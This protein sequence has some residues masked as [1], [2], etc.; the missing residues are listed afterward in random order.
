MPRKLTIG[1]NWQG[2]LDFKALIDRARLADQAGVHSIWVAEAWGRD[3]FTLLT[4]L[5]EH[6]SKAQLA[7]SIVNPTRAPRPPSR[8]ISGRSTS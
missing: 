2:K 4:L 6:T 3:A 5:A 8:N 7:T 1:I